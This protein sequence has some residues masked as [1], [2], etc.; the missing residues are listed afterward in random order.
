MRAKRKI[1]TLSTDDR[2]EMLRHTKQVWDVPCWAKR[3]TLSAAELPNEGLR[4]RF[5]VPTHRT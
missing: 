4:R 5:L 2:G 1:S 3:Y